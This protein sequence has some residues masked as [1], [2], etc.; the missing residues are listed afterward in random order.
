MEIWRTD[1]GNDVILERYNVKDVWKLVFFVFFDVFHNL[2]I[3]FPFWKIELSIFEECIWILLSEYEAV[4][5][6]LNYGVVTDVQRVIL[7]TSWRSDAHTVKFSCYFIGFMKY[8]LREKSIRCKY[9]VAGCRPYCNVLVVFAA[10]S[11]FILRINFNRTFMD[12]SPNSKDSASNKFDD[13]L[14]RYVQ[15]I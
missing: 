11:W 7:L 2:F 4:S 14:S 10:H 8:W 6:S 15:R 5:L 3:A 12:H 1:I 9:Q 13:R